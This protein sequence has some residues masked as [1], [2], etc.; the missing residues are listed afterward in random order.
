VLDVARDFRL[1]LLEATIV[2]LI[3]L[4]IIIGL[5]RH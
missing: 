1:V 2:A 3:V 5:V 4:E